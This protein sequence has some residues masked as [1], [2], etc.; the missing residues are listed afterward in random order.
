M[1]TQT[2]LKL[3][4]AKR[5]LDECFAAYTANVLKI[6]KE[7]PNNFENFEHWDFLDYFLGDTL[8]GTGIKLEELAK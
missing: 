6:D 3:D 2:G 1:V 4:E 7:F 5:Y 8:D